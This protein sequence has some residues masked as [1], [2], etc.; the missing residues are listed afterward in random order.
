[1]YNQTDHAFDFRTLYSAICTEMASQGFIV[2]SVEHRYVCTVHGLLG[3]SEKV[4]HFSQSKL[5]AL[6]NILQ[7]LTFE[8]H[9][10]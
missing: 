8:K 7:F 6:N 10:F 9:L 5:Q 1:M 4:K 2:A 3:L